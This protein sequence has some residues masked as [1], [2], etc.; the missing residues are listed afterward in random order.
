MQYQP[1]LPD[2]EGSVLRLGWPGWN[3]AG[4][5]TPMQWDSADPEVTYLPPHPS[6]TRPN[7]ADQQADPSSTLSLV[8]ELITLRKTNP[9]LGSSGGV[10]ILNP[11]YPFVYRR[12]DRFTIAVNPAAATMTTDIPITGS[13]VLGQGT[14]LVEGQLHMTGSSYAIFA[15]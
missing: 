14:S 3:R 6:P 1:G 12:G 11:G 4:S 10:E 13:Q 9:E 5:R 15:D 8:R 2:L 7:V